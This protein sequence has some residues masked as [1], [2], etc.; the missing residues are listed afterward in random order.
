MLPVCV[1]VVFAGY[2]MEHNTVYFTFEQRQQQFTV[3]LL[4]E[5]FGDIFK[6]FCEYAEKR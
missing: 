2:R 3:G 5:C 4:S 1:R 6:Y